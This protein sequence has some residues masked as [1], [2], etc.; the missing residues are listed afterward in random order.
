MDTNQKV[1]SDWFG[2]G[3]Y[4]KT[5]DKIKEAYFAIWL[6]LVGVED[7]WNK[8]FELLLDLYDKGLWT[9]TKDFVIFN[10]TWN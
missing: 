3:V 10:Q 8:N 6:F 2:S 4:G 7:D 5:T 9:I 1:S